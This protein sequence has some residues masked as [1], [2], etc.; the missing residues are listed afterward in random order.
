M[1]GA[2]S[3][4]VA[5]VA[6]DL[7]PVHGI[8]WAL[9]RLH[10]QPLA[11]Y[12][13]DIVRSERSIDAWAVRR[14]DLVHLGAPGPTTDAARTAARS[15]GIRTVVSHHL[16]LGPE[17]TVEPRL[18]LSPSPIADSLLIERGVHP[19]RIARWGPGVDREFFS[20]ARYAPDVRPEGFTV[21]CTSPLTAEHGSH[22]LADAMRL[23]LE[24]GP[25]LHLIA[26][27]E[28]PDAD[29]LR[30]ALGTAV[31]VAGGLGPDD[32]ARLYASADLYVSPSGNDLFG[33]ALL[34]AQASGLPV[35]A[36]DGGAASALIETGRDGCLVPPAPDALAAAIVGL[37]R[38]AALCDRLVTG[39]L[40]AARERSWTQSRDE[41]A[42]AYRRALAPEAL[43][44]HHA[45]ASEVARA[46]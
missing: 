19:G 2:R 20:P 18:F 32:A 31:T 4:R 7:G 40:V 26:A 22:L 43:V 35:V 23:A 37:A 14:P 10:E 5:I 15:L 41:L 1:N 36:V 38:R 46:A 33:Q 13:V 28:G 21:L 29:G 6:D 25:Q 3:P 44:A 45:R 24:R 34:E 42:A 9:T 16:A 27:G 12:V 17:T 11:G 8:P 39:G 30:R